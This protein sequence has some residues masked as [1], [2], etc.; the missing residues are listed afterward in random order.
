[1]ISGTPTYK[2][3]GLM[4]ITLRRERQNPHGFLDQRLR[5]RVSKTLMDFEHCFDGAV[6]RPTP[7]ALDELREAT[8]QLMRAASR[9]L[10]EISSV[11]ARMR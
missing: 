5:S 1:M 8:D 11:D 7:E 6:A 2:R 3:E 10:L 4:P 9:V